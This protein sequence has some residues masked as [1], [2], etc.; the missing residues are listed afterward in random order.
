MNA[1]VN[2][3]SGH[4]PDS[5]GRSFDEIVA[6]SFERL[7]SSHDYIQWLFPLR[8]PSP[9][10]PSAPTLDDVTIAAFAADPE[11]RGALL[12]GF[13]RMLGFY[14]L[15]L[16]ESPAARGRSAEFTIAPGPG[17][18]ER[19]VVWLSVGNHNFLRL[20]RIMKS[21]TLLG[22][23]A[24]AGALLACLLEVATANPRVIGKGTVGYWVAA[25]KA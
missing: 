15:V 5:R 20:T 1:L 17:F 18:A 9:V 10:N 7:E 3:F 12:R 23:G 19:A 6:F 24:Q 22:C 13:Y 25:A 2:F 4:A 16:S 21:L 14:G 11:L 8:E